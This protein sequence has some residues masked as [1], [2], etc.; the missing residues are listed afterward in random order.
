MTFYYDIEQIEDFEQ[1]LLAQTYLDN[2][3]TMLKGEKSLIVSCPHSVPQT[4]G[5][6]IK[7]AETRTAVLG[8]ILNHELDV[9]LIFKTKNCEDDANFDV[10]CEYKDALVKYITDH[11]TK[12]CV[13]LHIMKPNTK[14]D[15]VLGVNGD[16]NLCGKLFVK[17]IIANVFEAAGY[18][19]GIDEVFKASHKGTVSNTVARECSV[20]AIQVEL[21]WTIIDDWNKVFKIAELLRQCL[22]GI[23]SKL[24]E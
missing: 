1:N 22:A 24:E 10:V 19:V 18:N 15:V 17:H 12:C 4:R 5:N 13:D 23:L 16:D 6:R 9:P 8:C 2:S 11:N 20:P 14:F 3:F 21:R 7:L